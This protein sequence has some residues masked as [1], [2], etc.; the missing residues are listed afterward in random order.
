MEWGTNLVAETDDSE[1]L[2]ID[3]KRYDG[4]RIDTGCIKLFLDGVL[5]GETGA[6]VDPY[7]GSRNHRG[8]LNFQPAA[9]NALVRRFD[10][11]GLQVHMHAIGDRAVRAGLDAVATARRANGPRD[12]RHHISHLQL[13]HPDDLPRF[14]E[15]DVGA[16]FQA[17]WAMPDAW[18]TQINLPAVGAKRVER[19]YPIGS[20]QRAGGRLIGGSDWDVSSMNP[21]LAI[22]VA[23]TRE[24]PEG[25]L[26]GTLNARERVDLDTMLA[27]YTIHGAWAMHQGDRTG[28]I[29]VGKA[30]DLA[31]LDRNLFDLPPNEIA[32]ATV[33][34]TLI[35]G[36]T[37]YSAAL[38]ALAALAE[39]AN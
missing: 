37:V 12:N 9:L 36:E 26:P 30:A 3:R 19:M 1:R 20:V 21:L 38:A 4:P 17:L 34:R 27:A 22:Q 29:E 31:V 13:I 6:L 14:A 5:E 24:D 25:Q 39:D 16:T 23:L 8:V 28:S 33:V 11:E 32:K 35:D 15:L 10:A 2:L 7:L 18:I